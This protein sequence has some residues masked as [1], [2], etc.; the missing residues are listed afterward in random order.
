MNS[1][2]NTLNLRMNK[3]SCND[4]A[5]VQFVRDHHETIRAQALLIPISLEDQM[6]YQ[7]RLREFLKDKGYDVELDWMVMWLNQIPSGQDFTGISNLIIPPLTMISELRSKYETVKVT[8]GT[9]LGNS[10]TE[11]GLKRW[12]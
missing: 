9:Q 7:Y 10:G 6:K 5:W 11:T 2:T 3:Y 1:L 4:G 8:D 12:Y